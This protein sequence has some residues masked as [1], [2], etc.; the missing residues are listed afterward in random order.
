G[1]LLV[2][3]EYCRFGN[4]QNYIFRHRDQ[5]VDQVDPKTGRIDYTIGQ[6]YFDR[7]YSTSSD[8]SGNESPSLKRA[9]LNSSNYPDLPPAS[10]KGKYQSYVS[11]DACTAQDMT[12]V[13]SEESEDDVTLSNSSI[14]P[15]WR[16]N[17]KGDYKGDVKPICTKDLVVWAFQAARGMDYLA[18]R[19]VLHGD[20]AARN[21]LL[22]EDNVVKIC[23]FGLAKNMYQ[24]DNYIK[25]GKG[26][27][28]VKWMAVESIRDGVFS[29]QSDVWSF[30]IVLWEFFSLARS[31]YPGMDADERFF[32]KLIEGYRMESPDYAPKEIYKMMTECWELEPLTRPSFA[33]LTETIGVLLESTVMG[34]YVDLNDPYVVLNSQRF[35]E[36][37]SDYLSLL[38]PPTYEA[39]SSPYYENKSFD[40]ESLEDLGNLSMKPNTIFNPRLEEETISNS[41]K[42]SQK[43]VNSEDENGTELLSTVRRPSEPECE[44]PVQDPTSST[45]QSNPG[46][47]MPS[48][49]NEET[50]ENTNQNTDIVG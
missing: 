22:A 29:T 1:E 43:H 2:I 21:I 3:V 44:V 24:T 13:T 5:Y 15:N 23:D 16:S 14:Q 6:K 35:E 45:S 46:C 38:S 40:P 34:H 20:L 37:Q 50:R 39:L 48:K 4:L 12:T 25:K 30:G 31:P 9:A 28:P 8:G 36:G 47:Y 41:S 19:K 33:K 17:Y 49:I 26:P 27:L 18:S 42:S 11:S 32:Q 7:T 10:S